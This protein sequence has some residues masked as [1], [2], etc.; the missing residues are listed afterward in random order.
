MNGREIGEIRRHL[1]RE[2]CNMQYIYGCFVDSQKEI[3]SSF[4]L[5]TAMMSQNESD[6][7]FGVL[8]RTLSGTIGKNLI[9]VT[10]RTAQVVDSPEHKMLMQLR[11]TSLQDDDLRMAFYKKIIEAV[12]FDDSYVILLESDGKQNLVYKHAVST[13]IPSRIINMADAQNAE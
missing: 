1:H 3:I 10:F 13:V 2:R 9:D 8:R 11:E 7:Y 6:K 12:S 4:R 5:S